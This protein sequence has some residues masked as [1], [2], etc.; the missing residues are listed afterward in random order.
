MTLDTGNFLEDSYPQMEQMASSSVPL[1]LVQAKTY[2]G[3]GRWY[4]LELDYSR[5]AGILKKHNYR[6]W[7]SLEFEGNDDPATGVPK[8]LELLRKCFT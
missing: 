5:I 1:A 8:S 6:G 4:A 3:G 2:Y 7:I